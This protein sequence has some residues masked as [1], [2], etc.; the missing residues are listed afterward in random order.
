MTS[1]GPMERPEP[2]LVEAA[3]KFG[4]ATLHEAMGREGA[5][6]AAIE[7]VAPGMTVRGPAVTVRA[8]PFN[9]IDIHRA[10]YA[11]EAGDVLL[12]DVGGGYEG[13]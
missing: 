5:L 2:S 12:V 8:K 4:S 6:P 11:A 10:I 3:A 13:G 1:H 7:P 9:N